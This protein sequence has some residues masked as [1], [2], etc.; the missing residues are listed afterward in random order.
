MPKGRNKLVKTFIFPNVTAMV[1]SVV[2][3]TRNL[4]VSF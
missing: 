1:A 4:N 2:P 3:E